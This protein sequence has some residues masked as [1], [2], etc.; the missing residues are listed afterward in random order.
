MPG[1]KRYMVSFVDLFLDW[2]DNNPL[3]NKDFKASLYV[4]TN[5][6]YIQHDLDV[7]VSRGHIYGYAINELNYP[8]YRDFGPAMWLYG[9]GFIT[10]GAGENAFVHVGKVYSPSDSEC[11]DKFQND[12]LKIYELEANWFR[13]IG[14][15]KWRNGHTTEDVQIYTNK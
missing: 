5:I 7:S 1:L 8:N 6:C 2:F 11:F 13:N 10:S 15:C 4:N 14:D 12:L 9:T 3:L